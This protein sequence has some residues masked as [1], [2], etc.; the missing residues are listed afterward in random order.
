MLR[1]LLV[2]TVLCSSSLAHADG[3]PT[4]PALAKE[5]QCLVGTWQ[6][7]GV[8]QMGTDKVEVSLDYTCEE[9]ALGFG[10]A[11]KAV[12]TGIPGMPQYVLQDLWGVDPSDGTVHWFTVTNAGETHDHKGA[13]A[14]DAFRGKFVG[15]RD[16]K[17][18]VETVSFAFA[19]KTQFR[20]RSQGRVGGKSV[21]SLDIT[22]RKSSG[23]RASR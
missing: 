16:G 8:L 22:M 15:K 11:C 2:V 20:I 4:P 12:M 23:R 17:K 3:G 5:L 9:S 13:I 7:K 1:N 19:N 10:V 14:G 6:G 21:E 18:F